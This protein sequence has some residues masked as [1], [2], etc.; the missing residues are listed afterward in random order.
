MI[1]KHLLRAL[2]G[3]P[4]A[5]QPLLSY[6]IWLL[7]Q[8][9]YR[10]RSKWPCSM[11]T[12]FISQDAATQN[13]RLPKDLVISSPPNDK[14]KTSLM[15]GDTRYTTQDTRIDFF[16]GLPTGCPRARN[17]QHGDMCIYVFVTL[18]FRKLFKQ[19]RFDRT[20]IWW[21]PAVASKEKSP[22]LR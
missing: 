22:R 9:I 1:T 18:I 21:S 16:P 10:S 4:N 6:P 11:Q 14:K 13:Q 15:L 19:F 12:S 8:V 2:Y 20:G 5:S 17:S 7:E 3:Y